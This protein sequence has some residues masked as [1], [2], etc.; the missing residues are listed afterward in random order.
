[1]RAAGEGLKPIYLFRAS[2]PPCYLAAVQRSQQGKDERGC[3]DPVGSPGTGP[4]RIY[5]VPCSPGGANRCKQI[6]D[7]RLLGGKA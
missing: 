3:G 5:D 2:L 7:G 1:M 4:D 6:M